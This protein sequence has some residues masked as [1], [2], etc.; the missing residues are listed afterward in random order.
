MS[1]IIRDA[2]VDECPKGSICQPTVGTLPNVSFSHLQGR[3]CKPQWRRAC[4]SSSIQPQ[5]GCWP[6]CCWLVPR[7]LRACKQRVAI[8]N[9]QQQVPAADSSEG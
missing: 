2:C 4:A 1:P 7:D 3:H 8:F 9:E 6:A 5:G